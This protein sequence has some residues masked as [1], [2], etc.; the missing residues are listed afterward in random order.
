MASEHRQAS[1]M[2]T[3]RSLTAVRRVTNKPRTRCGSMLPSV[4]AVRHEKL[5]I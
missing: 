5:N 4:T 3:A 1:L 2:L